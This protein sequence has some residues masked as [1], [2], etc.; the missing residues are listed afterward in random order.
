MGRLGKVAA[1]PHH[2]GAYNTVYM[3]GEMGIAGIQLSLLF[4]HDSDCY[5]PVAPILHIASP[6][7]FVQLKPVQSQ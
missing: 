4:L 6:I 7:L 3:L 2:S 1:R 5:A